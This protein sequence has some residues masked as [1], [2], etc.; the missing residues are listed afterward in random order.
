MGTACDV[1]TYLSDSSVSC[2]IPS[3]SG[4][5][6]MMFGHSGQSGT[7]LRAFSYDAPVVTH[8]SPYNGPMKAGA[9]VTVEGSNF[10]PAGSSS[11]ALV[12]IIFCMN[13][14]WLTTTTVK[15]TTPH[16]TGNGYQINL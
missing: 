16:G 8:S 14:E 1:T 10:G 6:N 3:G 4:R 7:M 12:G 13:S 5:T 2:R 15:C 11:T 9:V